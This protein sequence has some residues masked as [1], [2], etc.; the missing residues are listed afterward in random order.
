MFKVKSDF[1]GI[2]KV[3][4][5]INYNLK[6]LSLLY[7]F[8]SN[9]TEDKKIFLNKPIIITIASICEAI[10]YDLH[11]RITRH[12]IEGVRNISQSIINMIRSKK[13]DE[14]D[15]YIACAKKYDFFDAQDSQFYEDLD[16]LRKL[17]NRIHIQN[18]KNHFEP[19]EEKVFNYAYKTMAEK[20]LEKVLKK[21]LEKYSR[22]QGAIGYVND[23]ELPW[24]EHFSSHY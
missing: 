3:G 7:D 6:T 4:D 19:D 9:A 5:N 8:Q 11:M 20:T 1:M 17:R 18:L 14:F 24:Q 13:I 16:T 10:L 2:F 22:K 23:F 21:M 15:K 12:T